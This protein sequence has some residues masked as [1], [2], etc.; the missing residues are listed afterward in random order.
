MADLSCSSDL[1]KQLQMLAARVV[2]VEKAAAA[3]LAAQVKS[4]IKMVAA[5][6]SNPLTSAQAAFYLADPSVAAIYGMVTGD[7]NAIL[8]EATTAAL[9]L[10]L[11]ISMGLLSLQGIAL[12]SFSVSLSASFSAALT[13]QLTSAQAALAAG[14]AAAL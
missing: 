10:E 3:T 4:T 14:I 12:P 11:Q 2:T 8:N 9:A 1:G 13:V 6:L 7:V 5:L